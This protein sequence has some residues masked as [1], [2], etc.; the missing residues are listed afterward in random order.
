MALL[1]G[2]LFKGTLQLPVL[3]H[4]HKNIWATYELTTNENLRDSRPVSILLNA[5]TDICVW[6]HVSGTI[7]DLCN[8]ERRG[9]GQ[10]KGSRWDYIL[11]KSKYTENSPLFIK[12]NRN[13][14]LRV[15]NIASTL[16]ICVQNAASHV[17]EAAHWCLRDSLHIK[18]HAV[19]LDVSLNLLCYRG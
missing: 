7:W 2:S 14:L 8:K 3:M 18:E 6:E 9:S 10:G 19:A 12:I 17:T 13:L 15:Y 11:N 16:T 1:L 4:L 5:F